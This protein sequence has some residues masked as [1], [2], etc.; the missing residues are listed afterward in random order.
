MKN[1][2]L[3]A[4]LHAIGYVPQDHFLFSMTIRDNI[5]FANPAY[6]QEEVETA[7]SWAVINED[8]KGLPEG[9]DTLVGERGVS[10]SGDKNNGSQL[11]EH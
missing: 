4:L 8:I 7:A 2:S 9:Y 11:L 10:L 1:Y 5:R 6:T 3:N